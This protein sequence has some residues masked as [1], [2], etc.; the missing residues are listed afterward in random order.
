V[1][2]GFS[3]YTGPVF[4]IDAVSDDGTLLPEIGGG[5]RYDKLIGQNLRAFGVDRD[6]PAT[7]FAFGT[8]RLVNAAR[9][10]QGSYNL[11]MII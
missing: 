6:V 7:G 11:E 10:P 1:V 4:Q 3:Y 8:E 5:G 9:L 2:R